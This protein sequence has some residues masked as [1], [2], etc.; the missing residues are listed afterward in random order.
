[1]A[2][3]EPVQPGVISTARHET[4]P[5]IDPVDGSLWFGPTVSPDGEWLY[6]TSHRSGSADVWRVRLTAVRRP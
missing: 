2:H 3:P 1:V 6:F 5:A 4:F